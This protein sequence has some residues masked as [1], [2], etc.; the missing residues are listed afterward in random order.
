MLGE[1]KYHDLAVYAGYL[2][3]DVKLMQST[4]GGIATA[5]SEYMLDLGGYV[6][7]VAYTED[8]YNAEYILIHDKA[9]LYRLKESKYIECDKKNI[10][11]DVKKLVDEGEKVL[12][13]G[14]PCTVAALYGFLGARP[15]NLVTCELICHGPTS[16]KVHQEYVTYLESKY[17]S[18]IVEFSVRRKK[19][20]WTPGYVYAKFDNGQIFEKPFFKTEYGFAFNVFG[21]ESCYRCRFKGNNR[22][23][24]IMIGDFWGATKKDEYWNK[25]G[26]S[27]IFAE[28]CQGN[29]FLNATPGI[30]LFPTTF[31]KAVQHNPM[32][33]QSKPRAGNREIFSFLL[34][35]KGLIYAAKHSVDSKTKLKRAVSGMIPSSVKPMLRKAYCAITKK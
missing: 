32:V 26:V 33:I 34:R 3:D 6:A 8:F 7:G 15:Q 5:L 21:R 28:T 29:V 16:P 23:G 30:K 4:S 35:E 27:S 9:D 18:K 13:F 31:E 2:D 1:Y 14:L 20:A 24:D 22:Y 17:Q 10:L 12:F 11:A 25:Y 19:K